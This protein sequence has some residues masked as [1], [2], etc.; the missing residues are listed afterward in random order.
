[1][2]FNLNAKLEGILREI[3]NEISQIN[4]IKNI[5]PNLSQSEH[6]ALRELHQDKKSII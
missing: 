5:Q 3:K 4:T 1:M 6:T 2:V